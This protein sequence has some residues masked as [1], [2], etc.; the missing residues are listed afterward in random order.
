MLGSLSEA[1]DTVQESWHRHG[2]EVPSNG[3]EAEG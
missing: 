1:D 3:R 2:H